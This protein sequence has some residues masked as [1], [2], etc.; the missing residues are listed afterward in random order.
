MVVF[1]GLI[2][3]V[4]MKEPSTP[5]VLGMI[6]LSIILPILDAFRAIKLHK[7]WRAGESGLGFSIK[8]IVLEA[9]LIIGMT[10]WAVKA[11]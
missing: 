3:Y 1:S 7:F 11:L 10:I 8:I 9:L 4:F 5:P 2:V 6:T